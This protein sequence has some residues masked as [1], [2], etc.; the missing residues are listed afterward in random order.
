MNFAFYD[1][2]VLSICRKQLTNLTT[3]HW[4][5]YDVSSHFYI[6]SNNFDAHILRKTI[7]F[8]LNP[9]TYVFT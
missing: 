3:L 4:F 5:L 2:V 7:M 8:K 6:N 9:V 1:S